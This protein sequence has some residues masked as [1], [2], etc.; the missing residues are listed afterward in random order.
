MEYGN[1]VGKCTENDFKKTNSFFSWSK[2][3]LAEFLFI[4]D[5][6]RKFNIGWFRIFYAYGPGQRLGS[7]IPSVIRA[8]KNN[9]P[10]TL[11]DPKMSCDFIHIDDISLAFLNYIKYDVDDCILNV[12]SGKP[13][14]IL[15][16]VKKIE[17][18]ITKASNVSDEL[19]ERNAILKNEK[20]IYAD[21][22][23]AKSELNWNP[24]I[25]IDKGLEHLIYN[26]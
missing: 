25:T 14:V 13:M 5:L 24:K 10:L 7:L 15:E 1:A 3:T 26:E 11:N 19:V 21:I 4:P 8:F 9:L 23:Q 20:G 17:L 22:S 2:N 18:I 16:I 6:E 12:G